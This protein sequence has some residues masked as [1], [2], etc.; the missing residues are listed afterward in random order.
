MGSRLRGR[1]EETV[2][3]SDPKSSQHPCLLIP[4]APDRS[5]GRIEGA[6]QRGRY[7]SINSMLT[8]SGAA[9]KQSF[10]PA[11]LVLYGTEKRTPLAASSLQ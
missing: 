6:G 7:R 1:W 10:R 11:G 2:I 5:P 8:P 3:Q 9:M 4:S